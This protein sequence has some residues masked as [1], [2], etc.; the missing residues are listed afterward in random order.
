MWNLRCRFLAPLPFVS[1]SS[2]SPE[3]I[4][5]LLIVHRCSD[6]CNI[7]SPIYGL[8]L[9]SSNLF[10]GHGFVSPLC[11]WDY[12]G[13]SHVTHPFSLKN[14]LPKHISS[15]TRWLLPIFRLPGRVL[16]WFT[17]CRT[18]RHSNRRPPFWWSPEPCTPCCGSPW[19]GSLE[20]HQQLTL[21]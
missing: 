6:C 16:R 18:S 1:A 13:L 9:L 7:C 21:W 12:H 14:S 10:I 15:H 5:D 19:M 11:K 8:I 2:R 3:S 17:G 4:V 20:L